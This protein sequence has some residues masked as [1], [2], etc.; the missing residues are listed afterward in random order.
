MPMAYGTAAILVLLILV[1]NM[2][3]Y[4]IM[5]RFIKKYT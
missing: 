5:R 1:I 2:S 3:A 4:L